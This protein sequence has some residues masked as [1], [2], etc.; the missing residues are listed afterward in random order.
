VELLQK[1]L[2]DEKLKFEKEKEESLQQEIG[3]IKRELK[4]EFEIQIQNL[5]DHYETQI[6]HE[7]KNQKNGKYLLVEWFT[8]RILYQIK[9]YK[10][11][12]KEFPKK[13]Q[14]S[15]QPSKLG[16]SYIN[17]RYWIKKRIF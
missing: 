15:I 10:N 16:K 5:K 12:V 2:K 3:N 14:K 13:I 8:K 17:K 6:Q 4:G 1:E 9:D 7:I 11:D